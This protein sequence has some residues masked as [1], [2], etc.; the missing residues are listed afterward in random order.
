MELRVAGGFTILP[1][2]NADVTAQIEGGIEKVQVDAGDL[3][4]GGDLI[5]GLSDRAS[6]V[7][8]RTI[9]AR[10]D[11]K[12]ARLKMFKVGPR[13]EE[14]ELA[15]S[16]VEAAKTRR[17]HTW[18]RSNE[19]G[20]IHAAQRSKAETAVQK[21]EER[22]KYARNDLARFRALFQAELVARK[23]I[24]EGEERGAMRGGEV[25]EGQA[26]LRTILADDLAQVRKDLAVAEEEVDV[27]EG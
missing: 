23:Q 16:E 22:L 8:L 5:A 18:R 14:I 25:G 20:E 10:I 21:A 17:E 19:A 27:A 4:R 26:E 9:E 24:E 1:I 6:R 13:P 2:Q 15:R 12:R 3:V 11:E 7:E